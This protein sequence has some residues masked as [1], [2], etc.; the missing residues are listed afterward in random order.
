MDFAGLSGVD[1]GLNTLLETMRAFAEAATDPQTLLSTVTEHV[2]RLMGEGCAVYVTA[3]DGQSAYPAALTNR[4]E[5]L[6]GT[7]H[8]ALGHQAFAIA[9]RGPIARC[10]RE[11]R[12]VRIPVVDEDAL[13]QAFS[14]EDI[15]TLRELELRSVLVV[16]LQVRGAIIGALAVS[17]HRDNLTPFS[18]NDELFAQTLADHAALA[19]KNAQL[20]ES[21]R[22]EL[23]ERQKAEAATKSF[24][25]LV[26]RSREFIAMASFDGRILFVNDAGRELI[27]LALDADLSDIPLSAFHTEDGMK[28]AAIL[29]EVGHWEG[30]GQLR[31]FETGE[32]IPTQVS[33]LILRG[34]D[35]SALCFATVQ[36]DLRE[37]KNLEERLRQAQKMEAIG[38]LAGGVAH[39]FNNLLSVI[40]SY[41]FLL[42]I[43]KAGERAATLTQQLLAF[44]RKQLLEP[45]VV[46]LNQT[47]RGLHEMLRRL[48]GE[49]IEVRL[50]LDARL[51]QLLV[52]PTQIEQVV[53]NLAVNAR[54]AMP[55]GG[56]LT[57]STTNV[58]LDPIR[59]QA[60]GLSP[61]PHVMLSVLDNGMGMDE[62]TVGRI[63]EPFFTTKPKGEGTGLGLATVFGIVQQSRGHVMVTSTLG[64][65]TLFDVYFPRVDGVA[66]PVEAAA[67]AS[68][69]EQ[70]GTEAILVVEDDAQV[71]TL[72]VSVLR[73][74][75]YWVLEAADAEDAL[76][77]SAQ[78]RR[79]LDLLLTDVVMP[80]ASGRDLAERL[81]KRSS[82]TK[83]LF[84]SGYAEESLGR[85][86]VLEHG[87]AL[88][89]KP[90]MPGALLRRVR[91][92]LDERPDDAGHRQGAPLPT[93][94]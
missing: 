55:G 82:E 33:S 60:R 29:R 14:H 10:I 9:S 56:V 67:R 79:R 88:L 68:V 63:F 36:R 74:A 39:D 43:H 90:I 66:V 19:L 86:G 12:C 42:E 21:L 6:E 13:N 89:K 24:V 41:S 3:D 18:Q 70:R 75:G 1:S 85:H 48:L 7:L 38:Q 54:D 49:H 62:A 32:L 16:P 44:S 59:A 80:R 31:H 71:R 25:A 34:L 92:I 22:S 87:I 45:R 93:R 52:D 65:G 15:G 27:G 57:V 50:Q 64:R 20:L 51:G 73:Q 37:T 91:E 72:I 76:A 69:D 78:L 94:S 84:V 46:D 17:R 47:L 53:M 81:A 58:E 5:Q 8:R 23:S 61:G 30:E 26:Q 28:R 35:G 4:V 77:Q 2:T 83:V 11:G 40:L